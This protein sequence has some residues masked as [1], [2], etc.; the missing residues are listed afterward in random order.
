MKIR[1]LTIQGFR[2]FNEEKSIDIHENLTLIY[3]PNSYGKTTISEA[4]E[5]LLYGVTSKVETADS[6]EEYKGSYRNCHLPG[7]M[8]PFVKVKFVN[9]TDEIEYKGVMTE[10]ENISRFVDG[11]EVDN[12][13]IEKELSKVHKPFIL[14]HA[15][16]NLLLA[17]PTERFQR[18]SRLL[19]LEK[20]DE[21]QQNIQKLCTKPEA[22][23]P[24]EISQLL[25][26]MSDLE[27]RLSKS[28]SLEYIGKALK[29]GKMNSTEIYEAVI[30]KCKG[31]IPLETQD[32]SILSQLVEIR[33]EAVTKIYRGHL[34]LPDYSANEI[35][36]N[37]NEE[38]FFLNYVTN[39]FIDKYTELL[40]LATVQYIIERA[41]LFNLG[42]KLIKTKPKKCPFCGQLVNETILEH[43]QVEHE[44]IVKERKSF[45]ELE[46][47]Q[48]EV[49]ENINELKRRL[50]TFQTLHM[51]KSAQILNLESSLEDLK[52]VLMPKSHAHYTVVESVISELSVSGDILASSY[53]KVLEEL[54]EIE[55]SVIKSK[56]NADLL[57]NFGEALV[58]YIT[59]VHDYTR[60]ILE[61]ASSI[62][63]AEQILRHEL[64][65]I[66]GTEDISLLIEIIEQINQIEKYF[67]I[68]KILNNLKNFRRA[69][70]QFVATKVLEVISNEFTSEVMEW[71]RQI[72]T[73]TDPDVHFDGFDI[74]R[75]QKGDLK[76][77]R[78]QI[79]AK[80]YEKEL[81]SAVS[82]LSESKLNALGL[83]VNIATNLKGESPFNFLIIDDPIQSWDAEH[84]IQFIEVIRKLVERGK[85]VI[86]LSHNRKWTNMVLTGCRTVGGQFYEITG[87]VET[88]PNIIEVPWEKW[89]VRLDE[90]NA[91]VNDHTASS[92]KLQQAEEEI[93]IINAEITCQLYFK[94]K[95]VQKKPNN[96]NSTKIRMML[97]EC[98][99]ENG[100]VD[101]IT[102]TFE[103]TDD[104]HHAP[105]EYVA[106]RQKIQR[107]H[108]WAHELSKFLG[109]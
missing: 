51:N 77:R 46:I 100:L 54:N 82:S 17:K 41:E 81:V 78:I 85:Q 38:E 39:E 83:C 91:T 20:L 21:I 69:T 6:K 71:Y 13:P 102:Q 37:S 80:S 87:Y 47:K 103:T 15:L 89:K 26:N 12:W 3:A 45:E 25:N 68:K 27:V 32:D 107:Y 44:I 52:A 40:K 109:N 99:I 79:K 62:S 108:G 74:D 5:W 22:N 104:A 66:A 86:L 24:D 10:D 8:S 55:S 97:I 33:N 1:N 70:D 73:T 101:R 61:N 28:P 60:I 106:H 16:K 72:K 93:R 76:A 9:K 49:I 31:K 94:I 64:D 53:S 57:K 29:N 75:T 96:L 23:I 84:E 19:G 59:D 18:F 63:D 4:L 95:G 105:V 30:D 98:G 36:Y 34:I 35:Q 48:K 43:I 90:V 11:Q 58:K 65:A 92:V 88:G 67:E 56:E 2:G 14:Q 7:S 50:M 42:L